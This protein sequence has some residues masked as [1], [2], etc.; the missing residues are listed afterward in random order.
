MLSED[1]PQAPSDSPFRHFT[2]MALL[3]LACAYTFHR[4]RW[5]DPHALSHNIHLPI[6]EAGHLIFTPFGEWMHFLGGSL[7]QVVF[8]LAFSAS[9]LL[10]KELFSALLVL[11]WC[12]DSLIDVSFYVGDAYA[13]ELQL[14]GGGEHDWA[15][16]LG[17]IDKVH[18]AT[19]L[20]SFTWWCGALVMLGACL[21]GAI[22]LNHK[23]G[24]IKI[25][26]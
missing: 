17:S 8:P 23:A 9:F 26:A 20:G 2:E 21:G 5:S 3:L 12:G 7:F 1:L 14:I 6:H 16:L 13:Q 25:S 19:A 11:L 10:R 4:L 24:F 15:Y 22:A 18:Y